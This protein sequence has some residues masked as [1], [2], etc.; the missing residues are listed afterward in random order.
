M[1]HFPVRNGLSNLSSAVYVL[2]LIF[3][4]LNF[5]FNLCIKFCLEVIHPRF[6]F[7]WTPCSTDLGMLG[8]IIHYGKR[9]ENLRWQTWNT[10]MRTFRN[11]MWVRGKLIFFSHYT[12]DGLNWDWLLSCFLVGLSSFMSN[13]VWPSMSYISIL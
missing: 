5:M 9:R 3:N 10:K 11:H 8:Q 2:P 7:L 1:K 12:Q 4:K 13:F 6:K